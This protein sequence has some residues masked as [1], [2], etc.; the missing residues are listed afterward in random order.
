MLVLGHLGIGQALAS[1]W[2]KRFP[3]TSLFPFFLGTLLPDV[4]DKP[5]YYGLVAITGR[6][7]RDLGLL[8]GTRT[9]GHTLLLTLAILGLG[10]WRHRSALV[11]ISLGMATHLFLDTLSDVLGQGAGLANPNSIP[12]YAAVVWPLMGVQ[13]PVAQFATATGHVEH[14]LNPITVGGE[15]IGGALL[16]WQLWLSRR[17]MDRPSPAPP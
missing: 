12:G 15:I 13:F 14:L 2:L 8:A 1:P 17:T 6:Y 16:V 10:R 7:G 11:A 9:V 5:L 4:I 3:R